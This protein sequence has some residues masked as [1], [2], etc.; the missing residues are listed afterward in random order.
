MVDKNWTQTL[1]Q[2]ENSSLTGNPIPVL[3]TEFP[4]G[5]II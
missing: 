2:T 4:D 5:L 3:F 1:R